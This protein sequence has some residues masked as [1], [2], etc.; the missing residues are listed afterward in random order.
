MWAQFIGENRE[1]IKLTT[2]PKP[3]ELNQTFAW[4]RRQIAPTLKVLLLIDRENN[5]NKVNEML[6]DTNL[7]KKHEK[8][9]EQHTTL[10]KELMIH[11]D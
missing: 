3:V 1:R 9:L 5:T 11:E 2:D 10:M 7:S 8:L 4:L 6:N